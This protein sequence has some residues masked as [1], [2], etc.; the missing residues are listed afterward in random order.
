MLGMACLAPWAFGAVEAWAGL[1]LDGGILLLAM[2]STARAWCSGKEI[3]RF[4]VPGLALGL[5]TALAMFQAMPLPARLLRGIAPA[6]AAHL[7]AVSPAAPE[8]VLGDLKPPVGLPPP[9]LSQNPEAS[10][11]TAARLAAAWILFHCVLGLEKGSRAAHR[12]GCAVAANAALLALYS[13]IQLLTWNGKIYWLRASPSGSAGPFVCHSHLAAYLNLGLGFVLVRLFAPRRPKGRMAHHDAPILAVYAAALIVVG[14]LASL[15]RNGFV[16]AMVALALAVALTRPRFAQ[17]GAALIVLLALIG[18]MLHVAGGDIPYLPRLQTLMGVHPYAERGR[19]WADAIGAWRDYPVWGTGFGTFSAAAA[20]YFRDISGVHYVH[21]ENEYLE[22]L[23]EGGVIGAALALTGVIGLAVLARRAAV[24]ANVRDGRTF[25]LG[26]V[27]G[28]MTILTESAGDFA[29]HIP[30]VALTVV[31]LCAH[32]CKLGL[33]A[34]EQQQPGLLANPNRTAADLLNLLAFPGLALV[35]LFHGI[36]LARSEAAGR[37]SGHPPLASSPGSASG[38]AEPLGREH[39]ERTRTALESA[40]AFRPDWAEGHQQLGLTLLKLYEV[41]T[42]E[43]L[44]PA[45]ADPAERGVLANVLWLHAQLH[46]RPA[47]AAP[48][49]RELLASR[50]VRSCLIPAAREFLEARRCCPVL[51]IPHAELA[52]LDYLLKGGESSAVMAARAFRLAGS[53][54]AVISLCGQLALQAD[55]P[56]L[57]AQ[58]LKKRLAG[59]IGGWEDVALEAS[60]FFTPEQIFSQIVPTGHLAVLFAGY[61]YPTP[62]DRAARDRFLRA[63]IQRLPSDQALSPAQRAYWEARAWALIGNRDRAGSRMLD[64]L[65]LEPRQALWRRELV[66]WYIDWGRPREAH[67]QALIGLEMA[68]TDGESKRA[69]DLSVDILAR[70]EAASTSTP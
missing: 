11:Q 21:A 13:T 6:T 41:R 17:F 25:V 51:P 48:R 45:I 15:S 57:L 31:I 56:Q 20:P 40:L 29:L 70:G 52:A 53:N 66:E 46:A 30:G 33:E 19:I 42:A 9:A 28:G 36:A 32:L 18:L 59:A 27:L 39:L 1:V 64:A 65:A 26:A 34:Q 12:F 49:D 61:L 37:A 8:S 22:W 2:L 5:I 14:I 68:P 38:S 47:G 43:E 24:A 69:W 16:G 50:T 58:V 62:E 7:S 23:V 67:E 54:A 60:L 3:V 4:S 35:V 55:D 63:A 44:R 10:I